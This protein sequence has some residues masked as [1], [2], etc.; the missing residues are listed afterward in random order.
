VN[1]SEAMEKQKNV[2]DQ[3]KKGKIFQQVKYKIQ[4]LKNQVKIN[5]INISSK[6]N[7]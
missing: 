5:L 1:E 4:K 6:K 7:I 3:N 2:D